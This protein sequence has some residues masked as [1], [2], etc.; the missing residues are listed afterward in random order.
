MTPHALEAASL[1]FSL[2]ELF[3][4]ATFFWGDKKIAGVAFLVA[5]VVSFSAVLQQKV[6]L[7]SLVM[8]VSVESQNL[9]GPVSEGR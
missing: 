1:G 8:A 4:A 2:L 7:S 9:D 5:F 3:G 6:V